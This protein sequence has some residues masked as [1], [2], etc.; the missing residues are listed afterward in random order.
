M[1][2]RL[3]PAWL[4]ALATLTAVLVAVTALVARQEP[5]GRAE[6]EYSPLGYYDLRAYEQA[7]PGVP[8]SASVTQ[9]IAG[10][11]WAYRGIAYRGVD[12]LG[13]VWMSAGPETNLDSSTSNVSGRVAALVVSP[14]CTEQGACRMWVGAAGG[15]IWRTDDAMHPTDPKWRWVSRGLGTNS[16]GSLGLDPNDRTANTIYVGT[17][18]TNT[19]QNSGAGTGLFKS[20]DGGDTWTRVPTMIVDPAISPVELDFTATRGI[21]TVI[22]APGRPQTLYVA[23][24]TAMLGMTGVRGGQ[25]QVTGYLQPRVGLYKTDNGGLTWSLLWTPPL[26]TIVPVNPNLGAGARDTMSGVRDVKLDPRDPSIIYATAWNNAIHRSAPS[27][28]GGDAAFKPVFTVVGAQR[29]RDLAMF[30]L[31]V[32][33]GHTRLYVYNGTEALATQG[34]YRLDNADVPA[35]SLVTVVGG[36]LANTPAWVSLTVNST[37]SASGA[38][39]Q[40]CGLQC[41]YDL[42]VATP[43]GQPDTVLIG[44]QPTLRSTNAGASFSDFGADAQ[45]PRVATHVDVRAIVFHPRNADIAFVGSDGGVVRNDGTFVNITSRCSAAGSDAAALC[46]AMLA[47]VPSRF[48]YL[49]KGLQTLQFFNIALDPKAP[50]TRMMGG[51]QDNSTVWRDGTGDGRT[52]RTVFPYGDGTS[53]SG[54]HP[55][56]SEVLFASFQSNSFFTN[57]RNGDIDYWVRTDAPIRV[58]GELASVTASTG[59]QFLTFDRVNPNT[60]FTGFQHIWRTQNNGGPQSTLEANCR[61]SQS[62]SNGC[63]DW[64]PLGVPYPFPANS[65][66]ASSSR[67]PGD[68]TGPAY[69]TD[70][71]GGIIVAAERASADGGTLWA[72]TSVG[73]LFVS[74]DANAPGAGVTFARIDTAGM[75]N[76]FVTGILVDRADPNVA[77]IAYTGFNQI[78][79]ATPGH[80]FRAVYTPATGRATF[81]RVDGDLGDIPIN[82]IAFDDARGDLY[83]GT[84]YGPIVL[85]RGTATWQGAGL[86]F[87]EA[88][89]VDM[90]WVPE[91]RVL[92]IAT[93]GLGIFYLRVP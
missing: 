36:T 75:P 46:N 9:V 79:P 39:R 64:V 66:P 2:H 11:Y 6:P 5:A 61:L 19:P 90:E 54:F 26:D 23:T 27:L 22:V 57:F 3:L 58:A 88:L 17:G 31:T 65:T 37:T 10:K 7:Y 86:G 74:K 76:R 92:V 13:P 59:R 50:L 73:R 34:F 45:S 40:L 18:E 16:I 69:G 89:I 78:T 81:T 20:T 80:I 56:R 24:T 44:G 71:S 51:L 42:V 62:V 85:K 48:Y 43:P 52:W 49:N 72:A 28:E 70:R 47:A 29:M 82:T 35:A 33:D 8:G 25:T 15:G 87:P 14:S 60:Q 4:S 91:E 1:R 38:S 12:P 55:S 21:S 93:H 83:A 32:K 67:A 77:L 68:L 84:D 30:D 63:G 53:A 41:F